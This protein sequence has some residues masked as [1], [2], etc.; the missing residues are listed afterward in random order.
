MGSPLFE[1]FVSFVRQQ[2]IVLLLNDKED[3]SSVLRITE[4]AK[5]PNA[6]PGMWG[7]NFSDCLDR[8]DFENMF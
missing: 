7:I 5:V 2:T 8:E 3:K 4:G 6:A 1:L